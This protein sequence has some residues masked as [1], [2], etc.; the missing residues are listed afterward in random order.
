MP[1]SISPVVEG[2]EGYE[3]RLGGE[4]ANQPQ[5]DELAALRS[6]EGLIMT[7]WGFTEEERKAISEGADLYLSVHLS[8][9]NF[10]NPFQAVKL[11]VGQSKTAV[12]IKREMRLEDD[13]ELRKLLL[14]ARQA[15]EALARRQHELINRDEEATKLGK[16]AEQARK[17]LDRKKAE[18]FATEKK[19]SLVLTQ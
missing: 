6:P 5:Y 17:R 2:L 15:T 1:D 14:E 7:R 19:S 3:I 8:V 13:Y 12:K 11:E 18:V 10:N 9:L 16:E 4:N